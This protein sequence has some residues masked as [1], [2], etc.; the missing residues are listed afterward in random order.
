VPPAPAGSSTGNSTPGVGPGTGP[1]V[2]GGPGGPGGPG[3]SKSDLDIEKALRDFGS[4]KEGSPE[5]ML[6]EFESFLDSITKK[7]K[8]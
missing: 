2:G 5:A 6:K 3:R 1:G 4:I 8:R 7:V